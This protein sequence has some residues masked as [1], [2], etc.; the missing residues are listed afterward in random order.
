[1]PHINII[2]D[3]DIFLLAPATY[4]I[5]GKIANGIADDLV[6][7]IAAVCHCRKI[8]A[9]AMNVHMFSKQILQNNLNILRLNGWEEIPPAEGILACGHKGLGKL[10]PIEN[11][12]TVINN[13]VI[14]NDNEIKQK[15]FLGKKILITAGGTIEDIDPV[16]YIGNKSSGK[17]GISL[18]KAAYKQGAVVT[19]VHGNIK[20]DVP[21]Y[22][23]S[24]SVRSA[25]QMNDIVNREIEYHDILI[26]AAAVAD[27][28]AEHIQDHKI[29]KNK[30][31]LSIDLVKTEDI[32][33]NLKNK[34]ENK[35][36][37]GFAAESEDLITNAKKKMSEKK[38]D[39]IIANNI[40]SE[41]SGFE[42]D[43]N[44]ISIIYKD[45]TTEELP[46]MNKDKIAE[47][48][49]EKSIKYLK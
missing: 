40:L 39:M 8:F 22:I 17:M 12:L 19:L 30:N 5:I 37:I 24:I 25:K 45:G 4:N 35:F 44:Q 46:L 7:T 42:S 23:S 10:A 15:P 26:M 48:I 14:N 33:K 9:P 31:S 18:C 32:L 27:F 43:D 34:K 11:I 41:K 36:F 20:V 6:S 16:R 1:M 29:K 3:A 2:D 28:K 38:L 47:I 21:S 13:D 49:L